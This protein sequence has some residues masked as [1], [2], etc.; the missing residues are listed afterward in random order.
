MEASRAQAQAYLL[1]G[2]RFAGATAAGTAAAASV[3]MVT[4]SLPEA[5]RR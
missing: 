2:A 3:L 1:M 4:G 5:V